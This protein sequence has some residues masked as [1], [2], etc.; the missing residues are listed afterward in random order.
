MR[1]VIGLVVLCCAPSP[2]GN[3]APAEASRL[4]A[5]GLAPVRLGMRVAAAERALH[6]RLGRLSRSSPGF[7]T[8]PESSES[9]WL[10]RRRDGQNADI[11]YMTERGRI[12]RIDVGA[13]RDGR[14]SS[15]A[16]TRGI[17]IGSTLGDVERTY[18]A[19]L[20]L[21]SHTLEDG[22]QWAVIE[23]AV[24]AGVR[25]E[26]RGGAVGAMFDAEGAALDYPEGCS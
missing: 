10:W 9:C 3:A 5:Q 14:S 15:V 11:T 7:A 26:V 23:R 16:T 20:H 8:E 2:A 24:S 1:L 21:E 19:D 18:G 4:T 17:G 12:V 22:T 6:A 25:I 13:T